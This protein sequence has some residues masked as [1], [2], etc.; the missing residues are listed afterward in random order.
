MLHTYYKYDMGGNKQSALV[1]KIQHFLFTKA[2]VV[3][4][5][6]CFSSRSSESLSGTLESVWNRLLDYKSRQGIS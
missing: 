6:L 2:S 4:N 1:N 5:T 3:L